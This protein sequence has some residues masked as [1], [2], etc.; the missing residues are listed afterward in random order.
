M[1][2]GP[3][4]AGDVGSEGH[5]AGGGS[6]GGLTAEPEHE[7]PQAKPEQEEGPELPGRRA[8][9]PYTGQ[10]RQQPQTPVDRLAQIETNMGD[11]LEGPRRTVYSRETGHYTLGDSVPYRGERQV[12]RPGSTGNMGANPNHPLMVNYAHIIAALQ[13]PK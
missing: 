9:K 6:G 4:M 8:G 5:Y 1:V 7:E 12:F 10:H 3:D 2:G 11:K 13:E